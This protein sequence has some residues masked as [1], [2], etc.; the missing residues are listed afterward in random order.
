M[1][2]LITLLLILSFTIKAQD[3][4]I[5]TQTWTSKNLEVT[6]YRNGEEQINVSATALVFMTVVKTLREMIEQL[7]LI[8]Q[9]DKLITFVHI[10]RF[11]LLELHFSSL[12]LLLYSAFR[13]P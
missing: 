13:A 10:R 4:T 3:V 12:E 9:K 11:I 1:K 5:G 8:L 7:Q 2:K 6:K